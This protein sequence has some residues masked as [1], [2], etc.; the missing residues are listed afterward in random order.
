MF[1]LLAQMI[2][3]AVMA[4]ELEP[5]EVVANTRN[6]IIEVSSGQTVNFVINLSASGNIDPLVTS[7]NP[8]TA[9]INTSYSVTGSTASASGLSS[10]YNFWN[11][12]TS[13][14]GKAVTWTGAPNEYSISASA[15]AYSDATPGDYIIRIGTVITNPSGI[16]SPG[17][18]LRDQTADSLTIRVIASAAPLSITA[19]GT[20]TVEGNTIGGATIADLGTPT[21]TGGVS[22]VGAATNNAPATFPLG[23]TTVTWSV[24][25]SASH[26]ATATQKVTVVDTTAPDITAPADKTVEGNTVGGATG[27]ALGSPTVSDLVDPS[28]VVTNDAPS[29]F[30]LGDTTVTWTAT[31]SEGNSDT[32]TQ[33][34]T[35]VDTTA[36][37]IT[38]PANKNIEGNDIGGANV[39]LSDLGTATAIDVV[40]SN[41]TIT[42][43]FVAQFYDLGSTTTVTWTA[44]DASGKSASATQTFTV[45]DTKPP[46]ITAPADVNNVEGNTI[47]GATGVIL[48]SPTV[49]D[50]VDANPSVTNNAPLKFPLGDT[51]VTWKATDASGNFATATQKVTVVDTTPP[52]I[53]APADK[54]VEGNTIGGYSGSIGEATASDIVD[55]SPVVTNNAPSFFPLGDTTVTW[56]AKDASGNSATATQKVTVV[57]TTPPSITAPAGKTVEGNTVGGANGVSLGTPTVLD[58]V[59]SSP[60]VTNDAP[61]FFPLGDTTVKWTATDASGNSASAIQTITVVDTT[62]PAITVPATLTVLVN[63]PKSEFDKTGSAT[64]IVDAN[65]ILTNNA[66][67][68]FPAGITTV[69]WTA[70]DASGNIAHATTVVTGNYN[71]LD[72]K[73]LQP[74]NMDGNSVFKLKSTVPT[75]FQL[76]DYYGDY[77]STAVANLKTTKFSNNAVG[78]D[79]ET[80]STAAA[81]T[82][83]LFRYDMTSN[84]YI[85][86]LGTKSLSTGGYQITAVLDSGQKIQVV[87]SLK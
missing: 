55:D 83:T 5:V 49:S 3:P 6:A 29:F 1:L 63:E 22:P 25:D 70:T 51:T 10:T 65:P 7:S 9:R 71:V 77:V 61:S 32:A 11:D 74:I 16:T 27:V 82:G 56:T 13:P 17:Q 80:I 38:A 36:P 24:T 14:S 34:I 47:G 69:T 30:P 15:T 53:T 48:G 85:F 86:N 73:F 79:V 26:T 59:D 42:N 84:Q 58:I 35:V 78:D 23:D 4:A 52:S 87:I 66:P 68:V 57:D 19:P 37:S 21:V 28:P 2:V 54:T 40:D 31:D 62:P 39:V 46:T 43:D 44:T 64:D 45:V 20:L 33:T 81:T 50:I 75:K 76:T 18:T 12:A 72:L 60:T 67:S 8:S 41:P